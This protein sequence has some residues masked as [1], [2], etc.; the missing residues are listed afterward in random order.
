MALGE[1]PG[2]E[3]SGPAGPGMLQTGKSSKALL[4]ENTSE[5]LPRLY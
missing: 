1:R 5:G 2:E 3:T 4:E